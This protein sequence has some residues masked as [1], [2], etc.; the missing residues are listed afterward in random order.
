MV[1]ICCEQVCNNCCPGF[2]SPETQRQVGV[3]HELTFNETCPDPF[4]GLNTTFVLSRSAV[5]ENLPPNNTCVFVDSVTRPPTSGFITDASGGVVDI[6]SFNPTL[7]RSYTMQV[8]LG[9]LGSGP[10]ICEAQA[11]ISIQLETFCALSYAVSVVSPVVR[12]SRQSGGCMDGVSFPF[13]ATRTI[14]AGG[15]PIVLSISGTVGISSNP[16]P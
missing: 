7:I 13:S 10:E 4:G 11:T 2:L 9:S 3:V 16:L 8:V 12:F 15:R 1:C 6:P 5:A 14:F